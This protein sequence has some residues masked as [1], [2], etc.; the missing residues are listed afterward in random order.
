MV[1]RIRHGATPATKSDEYLSLMRTVAIP[2]YPSTLGNT[3]AY[4]LRRIE[5]DMSSPAK[6]RIA[7]SDP[8][9]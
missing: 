4:A 8:R 6:A 7:S 1:T 3:G 2:D 5:G 9:M